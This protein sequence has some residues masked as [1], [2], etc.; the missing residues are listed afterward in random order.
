MEQVFFIVWR[1][2]IEALLIVGILHS[3]LCASSKYYPGL[4]Y[5]WGGVVSGLILSVC[6]AVILLNISSLLG[7]IEQEWFQATMSFSACIFIVRTV[8]WM[9]KYGCNLKNRVEKS[10]NKSLD[11]SSWWGVFILAMIAV[12]REGSETVF[13]L[14]SM[15]TA[16]RSSNQTIMVV[17]YSAFAL[18]LS[19]ITFWLLQAGKR[20]ISWKIFFCTTELVLLSLASALLVSG[21]DCFI[22]LNLITPIVDPIWDASWLLDDSSSLGRIAANFFGYRSYPAL[23]SVLAWIAYWIVI[24]LLRRYFR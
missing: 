16:S 5:L 15:L 6:F 21:L 3:W 4:P 23:I 10:A 13:F 18:M 9:K 24:L 17:W 1:E 8:L 14:F 19:I 20:F 12:A 11:R 7:H 22:S 2:S